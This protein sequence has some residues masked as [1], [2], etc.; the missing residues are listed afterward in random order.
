MPEFGSEV[1]SHMR[2][3]PGA[4]DGASLGAFDGALDGAFDGASLGAFDGALDGA[5]DVP[6][7]V[8]VYVTHAGLLSGS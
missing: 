7:G 8:Y 6:A 4:L 1:V 3:D 5:F 2:E